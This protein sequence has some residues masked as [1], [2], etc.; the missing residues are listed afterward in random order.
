M[1]LPPNTRPK[2]S[3]I[4]LL[5][6]PL[7]LLTY[8]LSVSFYLSTVSS[9]SLSFYLLFSLPSASPLFH[10]LDCCVGNRAPRYLEL[11]EKQS[12]AERGERRERKISDISRSFIFFSSLFH[13]PSQFRFFLFLVPRLVRTFDFV[14]R[15]HRSFV[16]FSLR[17]LVPRGDFRETFRRSVGNV[18]INWYD[19]EDKYFACSIVS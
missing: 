16:E 10:V 15:L 11:S 19:A 4:P 1:T 7:T 9:S 2:D 3:P 5:F 6:Y 18:G 17:L 14:A 13:F 12:T 8:S